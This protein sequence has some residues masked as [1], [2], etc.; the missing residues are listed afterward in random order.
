MTSVSQR[1]EEGTVERRLVINLLI[2]HSRVELVD[3]VNPGINAEVMISNPKS[4]F[5]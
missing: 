3:F 2:R 5:D 4:V 1:R